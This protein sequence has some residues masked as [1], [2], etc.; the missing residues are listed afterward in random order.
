MEKKLLICFFMLMVIFTPVLQAAENQQIVIIVNTSN[1][2]KKLDKQELALIYNG[3]KEK[4]ADGQKIV[5][6][7]HQ[8][9]SSIRE[10]FYKKVFNVKP[11]KKFFAPGSPIPFKTM[12]LKS[13]KATRIFVSRIPNA[14]GYIYSESTDP[15]IQIV[16]IGGDENLK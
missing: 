10:Q 15:S 12:V 7:N 9:D 4:W 11:T 16:Q 1:D 13:D 3:K 5:V 14:I 6:L 2:I 8:V